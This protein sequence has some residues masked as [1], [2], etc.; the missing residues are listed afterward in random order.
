MHTESC[1]FFSQ[2]EPAGRT[3]D[4]GGTANTLTCGKAIADAL[5]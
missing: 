2:A 5:A 3:A 4:I 1:C